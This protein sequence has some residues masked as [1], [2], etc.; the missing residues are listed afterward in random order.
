MLRRRKLD[1]NVLT[2]ADSKP[3]EFDAGSEVDERRVEREWNSRR[4]GCYQ[5]ELE[6]VLKRRKLDGS[7]VHY[8]QELSVVRR[9]RRAELED[10]HRKL[11]NQI[12]QRCS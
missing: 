3:F 6:K 11:D 8:K 1:G 12:G 10:E 7:P 9:Q 5:V 4:F 2:L